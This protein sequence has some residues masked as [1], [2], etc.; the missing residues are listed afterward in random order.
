MKKSNR[1][2]NNIFKNYLQ[3]CGYESTDYVHYPE[4]DLYHI[5]MKFWFS[6][7]KKKKDNSE[8]PAELF[9]KKSQQNFRHALNKNLCDAGRKVDIKK[10]PRFVDS[11]KAYKDACKELKAEERAVVKSYTEISH[12]SMYLCNLHKKCWI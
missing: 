12:T 1:N 5:L 10:D 6:V 8:G 9:S 2:A 7:H 3:E 11:Q 4:D